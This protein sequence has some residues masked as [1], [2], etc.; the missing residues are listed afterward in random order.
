[1]ADTKGPTNNKLAMSRALGT[2]FLNHQVEQ[3]EK[4]VTNGPTS[5]NW[6]D[7]KQ[8][9][10]DHNNQS[11]RGNVNHPSKRPPHPPGIKPGKKKGNE[12]A[13]REKCDPKSRRRSSED[14]KPEKDADV[15]V[16]DASVLVHALYQV[17]KWCRDGREEVVIVP[18][19]ALNTLDLLKK[20]TTALAQRAR[21]ASRIL[22]AQV[23]TNPRIL[24]Q[25]DD[26]FVPWDNIPF[27]DI[28]ASA[29]NDKDMPPWVTAPLDSGSPEWVRRTICC[30]RWEV[31][32]TDHAD[33]DHGFVKATASNKRKV[34]LAVLSSSPIQ[35][36]PK[37]QTVKLAEATSETLTSPVPLPAPHLHASKHEPRS[38]GT[39]VTHW[40]AKAGIE[41]LQVAPTLPSSSPPHP[42]ANA[43]VSDD[44]DRRKRIPPFHGPQVSRGRRNSHQVAAATSGGGGSTGLVERPAAVMAMMERVSQPSKVVRVLA[45]G[46]KLD[47]DP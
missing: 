30:A 7:R 27:V 5:G 45:R 6:R 24:V 39:L 38:A 10:A 12:F 16:V 43:K 42:A 41:M 44:E 31:E 37:T 32:N 28:P 22:E 13:E 26:A 14:F 40:A 4:S 20:G 25:R 19:E 15:V 35:L 34:L 3:L 17:K 2:A 18:L 36:S 11:G 21:A 47:P 23:G 9:Q 46:E 33:N 29:G 8:A 1:M